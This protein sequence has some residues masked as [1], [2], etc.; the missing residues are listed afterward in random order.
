M[1]IQSAIIIF[2]VDRSLNR[3]LEICPESHVNMVDVRLFHG[4]PLTLFVYLTISSNEKYGQERAESDTLTLLFKE[5]KTETPNN[6]WLR[7]PHK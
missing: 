3:S 5:A 7:V 6:S 2:H 4:C 1:I